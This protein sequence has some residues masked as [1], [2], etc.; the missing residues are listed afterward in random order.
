MYQHHHLL[1]YLIFIRFANEFRA[2]VSE[3]MIQ[4]K[5]K[6]VSCKHLTLDLGNGELV[7]R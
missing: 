2:G 7:A 6:I 3:V 4:Q 1:P 5:G